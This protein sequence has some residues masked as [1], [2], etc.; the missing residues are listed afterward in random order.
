MLGALSTATSFAIDAFSKKTA[1]LF[2][3]GGL[4]FFTGGLTP[5]F[6]SFLPKLVE[7]DETARLYTLFS[8]VM[9]I[10]PII[11]TA[12]L[13]SIYNHSLAYWPGLAFMVASA[14][15]FFVLF[16]QLGLHLIMYPSWRRERQ[17]EHL[18]QE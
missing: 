8:I 1:Y 15:D 4:A 18:Q 9:T 5:G 7:K 11:A 6:R 13:N 17:Q 2:I 14:Y 12:I 10:W 16:G 3:T